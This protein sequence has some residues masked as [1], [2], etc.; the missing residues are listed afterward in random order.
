MYIYRYLM[1]E[2]RINRYVC[3]NV[4]HLCT[5]VVIRD[6]RVMQ[7]LTLFIHDLCAIIYMIVHKSFIIV[8][9]FMLIK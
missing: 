6:A 4:M 9:I 5:G 3:K 2:Y 7:I 1:D 8:I